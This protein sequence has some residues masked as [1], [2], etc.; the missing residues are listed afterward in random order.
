VD[1]GEQEW[2]FRIY[3]GVEPYGFVVPSTLPAGLRT[4]LRLL[5]LLFLP[6]SPPNASDE[7]W[8]DGRRTRPHGSLA[9]G[10]SGTRKGFALRSA[11]QGQEE[12][13]GSQAGL[14]VRGLMGMELVRVGAD[15]EW[16]G[17]GNAGE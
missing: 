12:V 11:R 16:D 17:L 7:D 5:L 3:G 10:Y 14:V 2:G 13:S 6:S 9:L 15:G 8:G 4:L 1:C